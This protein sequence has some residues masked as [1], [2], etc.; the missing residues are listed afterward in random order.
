[1]RDSPNDYISEIIDLLESINF[2]DMSFNSID[3]ILKDAKEVSSKEIN[4][5]KIDILLS[6]G[7]K[8]KQFINIILSNYKDNDV[9]R[10]ETLSKL[11]KLLVSFGD[12]DEL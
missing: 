6:D 12:D 7:E 8:R 4:I 11:N 5:K 9:D 2:E 10:Q 3:K 1:M